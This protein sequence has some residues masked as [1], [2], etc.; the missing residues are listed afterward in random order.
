QDQHNYMHA[1]KVCG[2]I[3]KTGPWV[4]SLSGIISPPVSLNTFF[5]DR[6]CN[7]SIFNEKTGLIISGANSKHQPELATFTEVIGHDS[8]HMPVSS[9][10]DMDERSDRL[11]IAYNTYFA[12]LEVPKPSEKQIKFHF[13]TTYKWGDATSGMTLQLV[14]KPGD[15]LETGSG[16]KITPGTD[17]VELDD[18]DLGGVLK[19][20]GWILHFPPGMHLSWPVYTYNP[21]KGK[22][23]NDLVHAIATLSIPLKPENQEFPFTLETD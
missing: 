18:K 22:A 17:K 9:R 2:G 14:L 13:T 15:T 16:K 4:V 3:R 8:I 6:Q 5:L 20:N 23:E 12:I 10:L 21:Y 7:L 19:H 1:M 11:A